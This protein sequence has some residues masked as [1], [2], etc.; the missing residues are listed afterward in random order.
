MGLA[1][2]NYWTIIFCELIMNM[3]LQYI[4]HNVVHIYGHE[5]NSETRTKN[6]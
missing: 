5:K 3:D 1:K 4:F 6:Y 2:V